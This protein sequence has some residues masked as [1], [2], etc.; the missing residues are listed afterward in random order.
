MKRLQLEIVSWDESGEVTWKPCGLVTIDQA[1]F[2]IYFLT[3]HLSHLRNRPGT[4][5][6]YY[7]IL[8]LPMCFSNGYLGSDS[9]K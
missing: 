9:C 5:N 8:L 4:A 7:P 6:Q 1:V 2:R 3:H